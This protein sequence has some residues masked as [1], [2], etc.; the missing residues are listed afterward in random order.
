MRS[1]LKLILVDVG[2][3]HIINFGVRI[4]LRRV[5]GR[6]RHQSGAFGAGC[7]SIDVFKQS[8]LILLFYRHSR[9]FLF[10]S[11]SPFRMVCKDSL[12]RR[13]RN[14][15]SVSISSSQRLALVK[16]HVSKRE[17]SQ[18]LFRSCG[19][20]CIVAAKNRSAFAERLPRV[21]L[22]YSVVLPRC[23]SISSISSG[24]KSSTQSSVSTMGRLVLPTR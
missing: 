5:R 10:H 4:K 15:T 18:H 12:R 1:V 14:Y 11:S 16:D 22:V 8:F 23:F 17:I 3:R 9:F 24:E 20:F 6:R 7:H 21:F 19:A 2:Q 13:A